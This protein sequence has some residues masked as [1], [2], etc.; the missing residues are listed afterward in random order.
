LLGYA[1]QAPGGG[2]AVARLV[3]VALAQCAVR[4]RGPPDHFFGSRE[5]GLQKKFKK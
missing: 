2:G 5:M 3:V 4:A 1:G